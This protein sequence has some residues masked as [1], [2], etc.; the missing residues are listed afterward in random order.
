MG[1]ERATPE[2]WSEEPSV[3]RTVESED[4][5]VEVSALFCFCSNP[6]QRCCVI[7]VLLGILHCVILHLANANT[8]SQRQPGNLTY[9]E[10]V[11]NVDRDLR[12][13]QVC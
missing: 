9:R 3:Q 11:I 13:V 7:C 8:L 10:E 12:L 1:T 6:L 5:C 2:W 4:G